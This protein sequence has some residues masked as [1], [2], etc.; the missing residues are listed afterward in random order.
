MKL[1]QKLDGR[2][3]RREQ[4]EVVEEILSLVRG[5]HTTVGAGRGKKLRS[6]LAKDLYEVVQATL[7]ASDFKGSH[8]TGWDGSRLEVTTD[9]PLEDEVKAKIQDAALLSASPEAT[10][11]FVVDSAAIERMEA[12]YEAHLMS[13]NR[14]NE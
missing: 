10:I 6:V 4:R 11:Q 12:D 14:T 2:T 7:K 5:I 9:G 1:S 13:L 8:A 3:V